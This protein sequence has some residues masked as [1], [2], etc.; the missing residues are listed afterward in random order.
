MIMKMRKTLSWEKQYYVQY[1]NL[2]SNYYEWIDK[3]S[4]LF[5]MKDEIKTILEWTAIETVNNRGV[6]DMAQINI[7]QVTWAGHKV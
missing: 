4:A 7:I 1:Q 3:D 2:P 5:S 6:S